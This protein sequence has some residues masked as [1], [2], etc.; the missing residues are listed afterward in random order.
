MFILLVCC[1]PWQPPR[2]H[3]TIC[4]LKV[5]CHNKVIKTPPWLVTWALSG[6][7]WWVFARV[8]T[9]PDAWLIWMQHESAEL[10]KRVEEPEPWGMQAFPTP[11][12]LAIMVALREHALTRWR[13]DTG[14]EWGVP[15]RTPRRK[16]MVLRALLPDDMLDILAEWL[17]S[18]AL[19]PEWTPEHR[20][21]LARTHEEHV[22]DLKHCGLGFAPAQTGELGLHRDSQ[23][24]YS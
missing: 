3:L 22:A 5:I 11:M 10:V 21:V 2:F 24:S 7:P 4:A 13:E 14:T 6:K 1:R 9:R 12:P 19:C 17:R 16:R 20:Q 18:C 23:V 15:C 8:R